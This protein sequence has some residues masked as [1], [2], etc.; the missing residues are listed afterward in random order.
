[1]FFPRLRRG[2]EGEVRASRGIKYRTTSPPSLWEEEEEHGHNL[3]PPVAEG[4]G[5]ENEKRGKRRERRKRAASIKERERTARMRQG[6]A[7]EGGQKPNPG[8]SSLFIVVGK[9]GNGRK[10]LFPPP[11]PLSPFRHSAYDVIAPPLSFLSL[12]AALD[13]KKN[14]AHFAHAQPTPRLQ[15]QPHT[16]GH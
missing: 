11:P 14:P 10:A 8:L 12:S 7:R 6:E 3:L 2:R 1:M 16:E 13:E 15:A 9:Q 5:R 4:D